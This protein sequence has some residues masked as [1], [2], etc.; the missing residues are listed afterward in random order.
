MSLS[1][2]ALLFV[3]FVDLAGQGVIIP[4]IDTLIM[5]TDAA[6]LPPETSLQTRHFDYGLVIAVFYLSW[7]LGAV[8]VSKLSDSIGRKNGVLL[9]LAG[10]LAGYVLT[11]V[12]IAVGSLWLMLLGRAV[13]GFT[14]GNQ[15]I[16]QAAMADLSLD[17]ADK[18][19]NLG[20][21][22]SALSVGL[23]AGPLIAGVLSDRD[24][25]GTVASLSLPFYFA[26]ALV[27]VAIV[28][29]VLF[30]E[31]KLATRAPLRVRPT[32]VFLL[33]WQIR[34]HPTVLRLSAA[35]FF[36]M[37]VWNTAY[38]FMDNYLTSRFS[39]GTFGASMAT[40]V[41]GGA[42]VLSSAFLVSYTSRRWTKQSIVLGCALVMVLM[43]LL[44]V[45]TSLPAI[46]YL[47]IVPLAAAFA[48]GYATL[49]SLFSASVGEDRQGWVMGITTA[50]WTFG[51]GLTSLVGGDAMG[52]DIRLPFYMAAASASLTIVLI[53]VLWQAPGVRDI[54]SRP[55]S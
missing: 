43:S 23:V 40:F 15:P 36:F 6:F 25:L 45:F 37:F 7:F 16:A 20:Y 19:R 48:I 53:V 35:F 47:A 29:I 21:C 1:K 11:I 3:I 49:L 24:L 12:A 38:V 30:F 5:E 9:C 26:M 33:L 44:Y 18:T 4:L 51:A 27:L 52:L 10:A 32:E 50:L 39:I 54:A 28:L 42:L 55:L 8:Y 14:A 13:T 46:S 34:K 17:D 41:A 2:F 22:V 31:D